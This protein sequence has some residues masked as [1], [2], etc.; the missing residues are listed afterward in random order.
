MDWLRGR[1]SSPDSQANVLAIGSPNTRAIMIKH[2]REK[3]KEWSY[4]SVALGT[5]ENRS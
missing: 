2:V 3:K 1:P 4:S 5:S